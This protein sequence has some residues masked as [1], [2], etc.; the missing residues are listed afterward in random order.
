LA[1]HPDVRITNFDALTYAGNL[2]SLRD[3]DNDPRYTFVRGDICDPVAVH[4]SLRGHDA[5]V[6][7]A[8]ASHVDRSIEGASEFVRTNVVGANTLFDIAMKLEIPRFLHISTDE[9]YGS[10]DEPSEFRE[11][12][13]LE[14]NSPYAASKASADL[15]ARSYQVTHGYPITITR[16]SNNFGEYHFP[17]KV[18]PLFITNLLDGRKVP[19]YGD[20]R[21]IRDWTYVLDNARAQWLVLTEGVPGET[22]NVGAGN[23]MSNRDLTYRLLERFGRV[24]SQADEMIEY[25]KDRPGHDLR[26]AIDSS[27]V[28]GLGWKPEFTFDEALDRTIGWF[29]ENEWWWRPLQKQGSSERRGLGPKEPVS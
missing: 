7:F 25:V 6:N 28:R 23:Q 13:T 5:V 12:D 17:E 3:A 18:I 27:K 11:G 22:Y 20:G 10:I 21:N 24:S 1:G 15:L 16:S 26:Y 9:T 29:R 4:E 14:P 8:A 19:L 2:A